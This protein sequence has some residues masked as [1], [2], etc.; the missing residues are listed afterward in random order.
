MQAYAMHD[1]FADAWRLDMH[2]H[3]SKCSRRGQ[4]VLA[5]EKAVH[6]ADAFGKAAQHDGAVR[7]GFIAGQADAPAQRAT[8]AHC[9]VA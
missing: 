8:G 7:N 5:F 1:A 2:T 6:T 4:R 3:R 9:P